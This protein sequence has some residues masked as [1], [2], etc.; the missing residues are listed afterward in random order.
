MTV[1]GGEALRPEIAASWWRSQMSGVRPEMPIEAVPAE[2]LLDA[3]ERL[4]RAV[5]PVLDQ[6]ATH[7]AGT[8]SS[9]V[10]ADHRAVILDRRGMT[11]SITSELDRLA[12][13]PGFGFGEGSVGTNAIG[14]AAEERR[15]VR[16]AGAEHYAEILKHLSCF[17]VPLV[18]PL[19]HRLVGVL[20]L[21]FPPAEEHPLMPFY[22][23]EAARRIEGILA[24]WASRRERAQF[25]C[26]LDL[27]RWT[28]RAVLST[29]DDAVLLNR[30]ARDLNPVDQAAILKTAAAADEVPHGTVL[31]VDLGGDRP[32]LRLQVHTEA[33]DVRFPGMVLEL[34]PA[35]APRRSNRRRRHE[36]LAGLVGSS[37]AWRG[38]CQEAQRVAQADV[39]V[40]LAGE[41]GAGKLAV[42]RALHSQSGRTE[43]LVLDVATVLAD[44]ETGWLRA[45]RGGCTGTGTVIVRHLQLCSPGL[46]AAVA[47]EVDRARPGGRLVGTVTTPDVN[48]DAVRTLMD[49]FTVRVDVPPLRDRAEDVEALVAH[50]VDRHA[51]D[52]SVRFHPEAL[53]VL[54]SAE[55]PDNVRELE[56]IVAGLAATRRGDILAADLPPLHQRGPRHLT[57]MESAERDAILKALRSLK[58][59]K[60]A[61]A[62]HLGISRPTLYRKLATYGIQTP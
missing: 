29:M 55:F 52:R 34:L 41:T 23:Q 11:T 20:D 21:T 22:M 32:P 44:G 49:R 58:G 59:N 7:L 46:A 25:E 37:D 39:P 15:L 48:E 19:T 14:T 10:L 5:Q 51:R 47:A 56:R 31:H 27:A 8:N 16:V 2:E 38:L 24:E 54:R 60:A 42:A 13:M 33:H 3:D 43:L 62:A 6:L 40:L 1:Q 50:F 26:F 35:P 53:A 61:A 30:W 17:G 12:V 45:L 9:I 57:A 18:H 36:H 4:R 28:R